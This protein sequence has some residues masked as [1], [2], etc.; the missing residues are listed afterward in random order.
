MSAG[1][2]FPFEDFR[3]RSRFKFARPVFR[4]DR[5]ADPCGHLRPPIPRR[6]RQNDCFNPQ[7]VGIGF[8]NRIS[9]TNG[10]AL[11]NPGGSSVFPSRAPPIYPAS[12]AIRP[13]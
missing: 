7:R 13:P 5:H 9:L 8:A 10:R 3:R 11:V 1:I 12:S 2:G 6:S 4:T